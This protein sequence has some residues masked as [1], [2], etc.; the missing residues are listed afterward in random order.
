MRFCLHLIAVTVLLVPSGAAAGL[1]AAGKSGANLTARVVSVTKADPRSGKLVTTIVVTPKVVV[2]PHSSER[3][4]SAD[5]KNL[6]ESAARNYDLSPALVDSVIQ[7]ESNY[8]QFAVSPKGAQGLMQLMPATARRF[9]VKDIFDPKQNIEGGVRYLKFLK[10]TFKDERLAIAAYN[11]GEGAV[12]R[13]GSVPPYPETVDY[14]VKVGKK[15]GKIQQVETAKS[16]S[17]LKPQPAAEAPEYR[18][19][20]QTIGADGRVYL[21]TQ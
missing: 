17:D 8:D 13:Y 5:V 4:P 18:R 9:G 6:V 1:A 7:V 10:E 16:A 21:T 20:A 12:E 15:I 14:V 11:A 2:A 3:A 19:L